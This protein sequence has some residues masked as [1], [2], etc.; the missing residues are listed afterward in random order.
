ML[1]DN[2]LVCLPPPHFRAGLVWSTRFRT[3]VTSCK[4]DGT[5][6]NR[7]I[8]LKSK[9]VENPLLP[10]RAAT[11]ERNGQESPSVIPVEFTIG[12]ESLSVE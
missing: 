6:A 5:A 3:L 4:V 7:K 12:P 2:P 9:F 8:R 11:T 1:E 10:P